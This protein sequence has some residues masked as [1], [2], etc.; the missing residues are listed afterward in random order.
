MEVF[1][2]DVRLSFPDL[3]KRGRPPKERPNEPGKYGCQGIFDENS[4]PHIAL[5]E[6]VIA[7]A[8]EKWPDNWADILPELGQDKKCL[9]K[10]NLQTDG[11]GVVRD[12]YKGKM[13][14]KASN[15]SE[16]PLIAAKAKKADGTWNILPPESGKPY[17][18]CYVN[19]KVDVY[20]VD[21]KDFG[22]GIHATLQAVQFV[23]DGAAFSGA[24]ATADGFGDVEGAV[25][26]EAGQSMES[27]T[28]GSG[29]ADLGI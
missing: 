19:L 14:V 27:A 16:V 23:R 9:R 26:E 5:R 8:K 3:R 21:S 29:T 24:P 15:S 12:E 7:V 17:G 20:A 25:D 2:N 18:G 28:V 6:A 13:F 4:P 22:K 10:G 11:K 1:L